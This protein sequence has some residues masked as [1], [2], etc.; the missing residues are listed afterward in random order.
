MTDKPSIYIIRAIQDFRKARRKASLREIIARLTGESTELLSFEE[1]RQMLRA[2]VSPKKVIKDI[3]INAIIG[4]VNRYQDFDR[5]FL[6]RRDSIEERWTNVDAANQ[7]MLGLPPIE[8]YQI[9]QVYFVSDGH[10]R[11][12]VAK[13]QGATE[14]QAYVTEVHSR[15]TLTDDVSPEELIIKAE[16]AEFLEISNLDK[17]R[18]DINLTVTEPGQY[19]IIEEHIAVHRHY[20]GI[21]QQHEIS[22]A[23]AAIDWFDVVYFPIV[24]IIRDKG[25]LLDFPNRTEADLYLWIADHRAALEEELKGQVTITNAIEDLADQFSHRTDRVISRIGNKIYRALIPATLDAGPPTGEWRMSILSANR[26]ARLFCEILV[27]INGLEDGWNALDQA[28]VIAKREGASIH[29]L[30]VS[31]DEAPSDVHNIDDLKMEFAQKCEMSGAQYDLQIK[32]GDVTANICELA[33]WSDLVVINL[34][35]PPE[36]NALARLQS[37]IRNLIQKCPRPIL[38][39]PQVCKPMENV[40]LA[41]DN[42]LKAQEALFIAAYAAGQ[43]K[44]PLHVIILGDEKNIADIQGTAKGYLEEL[45]IQADYVISIEN[46]SVDEI[47]DFA[48]RKNIDLILIGGYN[49]SPLIEIIQGSDIDELLSKVSIPTLVCR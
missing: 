38:F 31:S 48:G 18:P 4:S 42:S 28:L 46:N 20:M 11:V 13:Q 43:W 29:G 24:S 41:Y 37:G 15:V 1:V 14:I 12:S 9:D 33:R 21:E 40:L 27:P 17:S 8:A 44:I 26:E 23:D 39:T 45:N 49:R 3:P 2:Q 35:Y 5:S 19:I 32:S 25:L 16:Y 10:H 47:L 34:T 30:F 36:S 6:P 7:E 22:Y